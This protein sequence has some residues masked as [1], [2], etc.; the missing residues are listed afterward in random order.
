MEMTSNLK[1]PLV[2]G[3]KPLARQRFNEALQ[4]IDKNALSITHE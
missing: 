3:D 2:P 4:T 1:I